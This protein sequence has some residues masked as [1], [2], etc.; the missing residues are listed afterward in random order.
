MIIAGTGHRPDKLSPDGY[1]YYLSRDLP[2][3][4]N[5]GVD[6]LNKYKPDECISGMAQGWD[7]GLAL[8]ALDLDIPLTVAIPGKWFPT[9]WPIEAQRVYFKILEKAAKIIYID[10]KFPIEG[11]IGYSPR[12]M[13]LRNQWMTDNSDAMLALWNGVKKGGT[14]N[15]IKYAKRKNVT[16][17]NVWDSWIKYRGF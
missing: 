10:E 15:N 12:Y 2:R 8:A 3:I 1:K 4:T 9:Q 13:N 11:V 16:V 5:L 7:T 17:I 6:A 14:W